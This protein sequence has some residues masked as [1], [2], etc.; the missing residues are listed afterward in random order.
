MLRNFFDRFNATYIGIIRTCHG[1]A[2][3]ATANGN[4]GGV[5]I[6]FAIC[7]A[8]VARRTAEVHKEALLK[9]LGLNTRSKLVVPTNIRRLWFSP[10]N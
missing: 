10:F 6:A 4:G 5:R 7:Y 2:P 3:R 8:P 9:E 1:N